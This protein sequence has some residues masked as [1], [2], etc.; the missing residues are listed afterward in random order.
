MWPSIIHQFYF[1]YIYLEQ[2]STCAWNSNGILDP[3]SMED[4]LCKYIIIEMGFPLFIFIEHY[5]RLSPAPKDRISNDEHSLLINSYV[6]NFYY[7]FWKL[8]NKVLVYLYSLYLCTV[9]KIKKKPIFWMLSSNLFLEAWVF[10][11][12]RFSFLL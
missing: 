7:M 4:N 6:E 5:S 11:V 10:R 3:F 8:M 9:F 1:R 12:G 2:K